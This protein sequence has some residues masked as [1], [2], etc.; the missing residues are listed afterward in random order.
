MVTPNAALSISRQCMLP[1]ITRSS[2]YYSTRPSSSAEFD[3][4]DWLCGRLFSP[5]PRQPGNGS[6]QWIIDQQPRTTAR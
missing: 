4:Q 5:F 1:W 3:L 2:F 6:A